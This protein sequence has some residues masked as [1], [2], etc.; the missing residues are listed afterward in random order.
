MNLVFA[1]FAVFIMLVLFGFLKVRAGFRGEAISDRT[2]GAAYSGAAAD[3]DP[4][5]P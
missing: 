2:G 1:A 4:G 5:M 3:I